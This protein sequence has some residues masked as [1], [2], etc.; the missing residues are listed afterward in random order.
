MNYYIHK[1]HKLNKRINLTMNKYTSDDIILL[2]D[3]IKNNEQ[4]TNE[5]LEYYKKKMKYSHSLES[6]KL[7]ILD[8][9]AALNY[10][11]DHHLLNFNIKFKKYNSHFKK[12]KKYKRG[13]MKESLDLFLLKNKESKKIIEQEKESVEIIEEITDEEYSD[14][15]E[16]KES[17]E[18][19][20]EE[21][22]DNDDEYSSDFYISEDGEL[23]F[24]DN[25]QIDLNNN[26]TFTNF[27]DFFRLN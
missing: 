4:L 2:M 16:E 18:I 23:F 24:K 12:Y 15:E 19:T 7:K 6:I 5:D 11:L 3:F 10:L 27:L 17:V 1:T 14:N 9:S 13:V 22:S 20:D 8:V 25:E 26:F 21:Y